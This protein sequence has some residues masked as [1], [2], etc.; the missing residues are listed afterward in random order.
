MSQT[1][2]TSGSGGEG[3]HSPFMLSWTHEPNFIDL[4]LVSQLH[5]P[6]MPLKE[7]WDI[8]VINGKFLVRVN[9]SMV[10]LILSV[11]GN[12]HETLQPLVVSSHLSAVVKTRLVLLLNLKLERALSPV[13]CPADSPV[14]QNPTEETDLSSVPTG[15][16]KLKLPVSS[17]T[18]CLCNRLASCCR[19]NGSLTVMAAAGKRSEVISFSYREPRASVEQMCASV[20]CAMSCS[21]HTIHCQYRHTIQRCTKYN[22]HNTAYDILCSFL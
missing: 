11:S 8:L 7:P 12:H 10:P 3:I 6:T 21:T 2:S 9:H 18:L 4:G 13:G 17:Q 19:S 20:H 22:T 1:S 14:A 16:R 5:I 15:Y